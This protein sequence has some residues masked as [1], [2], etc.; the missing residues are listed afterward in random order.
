MLHAANYLAPDFLLLE[1]SN[2]DQTAQMKGEGGGRH[3][4]SR[5]DLAYIQAGRS[6]ADQQSVDI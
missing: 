5:L 4:K 2:V 3:A 6:S 1:K